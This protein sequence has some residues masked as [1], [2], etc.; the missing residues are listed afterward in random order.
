MRELVYL[1]NVKLF[2]RN[3]YIYV[4]FCFFRNEQLRDER[5]K[6]NEA[7]MGE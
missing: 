3:W 2:E 4:G 7:H 1:A 5:K 6:K